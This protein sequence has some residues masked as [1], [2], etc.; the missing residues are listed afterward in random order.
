M[1]LVVN[2][3]VTTLPEGSTL[4]QALESLGLRH[5]FSAVAVNF[6]FVP[7]SRYAETPLSDGDEIE[8]VA[9]QQGG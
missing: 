6:E 7:R 4:A 3:Q 8:V 2:G 1:T 5:E 9:P